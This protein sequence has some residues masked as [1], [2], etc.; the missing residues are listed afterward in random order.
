MRLNSQNVSY[1]WTGGTTN[2]AVSDFLNRR[3]IRQFWRTLKDAVPL[4]YA[5]VPIEFMRTPADTSDCGHGCIASYR[6][7]Y[8]ND[9]ELMA[10][11]NRLQ[12]SS[13]IHHN[14]VAMGYCGVVSAKMP[15]HG[16]G[17][18]LQ[19]GLLHVSPPI[20]QVKWCLKYRFNDPSI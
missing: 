16:G 13:Q 19:F 12:L 10:I 8:T 17:S 2:V 7:Q 5:M 18:A 9:E 20:N 11:L 4:E 1:G 15:F 14:V 6:I 3:Y